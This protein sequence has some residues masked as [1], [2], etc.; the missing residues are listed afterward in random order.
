MILKNGKCGNLSLFGVSMWIFCYYV[1][2]VTDAK[3]VRNI[4]RNNGEKREKMYMNDEWVFSCRLCPRAC[5]ADRSRGAG[6]CRTCIKK[7]EEGDWTIPVARAALHFWEEPCIS[8]TEGSGT[9]FFSGCNL[10]CVFCQN[11]EISTGESGK[12]ISVKRLSE[13][14]LELEEQGA[15]NIN[16]VTAGHV[17]PFVK[18][19]LLLAKEQGLHIP[20][21]YNTS[22]YETA[23]AIKSL[24]GL[25]DIYLPDLKYVSNGLAKR[26]SNAEDYFGVASAA[27]DEM[28]KQTGAPVFDDRGL[29]KRGTIVR[30]LLLPGST[31]DSKR[32]IRYLYETYGDDIYISIMNQYTPMAAVKEYPWLSRHVP[33]WEYDR[34]VDMAVSLGVK[35]GFTQE[36]EAADESFIPPF[37]YTGV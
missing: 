36:G 19:A 10:G 31:M 13:I 33:K 26:Y 29:M 35:N 9:V 2:T 7:N 4:F 5:G 17:L 28:V 21:L 34:V 6:A 8:G 23:G 1:R 14:F 27:I 16:L 20:V 3:A 24:S 30:H 37:D 11:R 18:T 32:V 25:V 22:G 15:N 12:W